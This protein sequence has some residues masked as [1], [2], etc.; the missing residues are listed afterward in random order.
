MATP[1]TS[2]MERRRGAP[3]RRVLMSAQIVYHQGRIAVDCMIRNISDT[4][5]QLATEA[6]L[7]LPPSFW[8]RFADGNRRPVELVWSKGNLTGVRFIDVQQ[9]AQAGQ[10]PQ[11]RAGA[12]VK[13]GLVARIVEIERQLAEL[14]AE[15][16]ISLRD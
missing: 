5:A 11:A 7:E 6:P 4:G 1:D 9:P 12:G 2:E 14:R 16:A 13:A 10:A 8:L 15:I 3:R